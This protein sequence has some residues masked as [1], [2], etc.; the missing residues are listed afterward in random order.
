MKPKSPHNIIYR[1][2]ILLYF[3]IKKNYTSLRLSAPVLSQKKKTIKK[4]I[5]HWVCQRRY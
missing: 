5:P 4:T 3:G 2:I 1:Y